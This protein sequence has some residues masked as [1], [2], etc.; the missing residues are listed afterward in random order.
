MLEIYFPSEQ[1]TSCPNC[2]CRTEI[3]M[4]YFTAN[5]IK[6]YHSCLIKDCSFK[7]ILDEILSEE[8]DI[9]SNQ[10]NTIF[11]LAKKNSTHQ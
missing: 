4:E 7:F 8:L 3:I 1:P 5:N 9:L 10:N 11:V 2:G 6:Q